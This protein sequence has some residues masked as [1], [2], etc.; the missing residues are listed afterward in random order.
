[1]PLTPLATSGIPSIWTSGLL[2]IRT[3]SKK[4]SRLFAILRFRLHPAIF[5]MNQTLWCEWDFRRS[6]LKCSRKE[7]L[8]KISGVQF[9]DCWPRRLVIDD[10]GLQIAFISL[11]DLKRNKLASGRRKDLLD[12]DELP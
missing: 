1:M 12:L 9:E 7:V 3:T 4:P 8:K 2:P 6:A 5:L 11:Q 10:D